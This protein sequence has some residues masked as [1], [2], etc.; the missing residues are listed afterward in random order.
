VVTV[1][2]SAS[3]AALNLD[4]SFYEFHSGAGSNW[5]FDKKSVTGSNSGGT[6]S[7]S[8]GVTPVTSQ[9][10][11]VVIGACAASGTTTSAG[12]TGWTGS[13]SG[14]NGWSEYELVSSQTA[15]AASFTVA[16]TGH[17]W[18]AGVG[19]WYAFSAPFRPMPVIRSGSSS[20][21][22]VTKMTPSPDAFVQQAQNI[23][24]NSGAISCP[25]SINA[26]HA[27]NLIVVYIGT[28]STGAIIT[29]VT[30]NKNNVYTLAFKDTAFNA[31]LFCYHCLGCIAG[32]TTV[33]V[34]SSAS[35]NSNQL[36][37]SVYEMSGIGSWAFDK[38][39][40]SGSNSGTTA[41]TSGTT[42]AT[43][44]ANEVVIAACFANGTSVTA[45]T[46]GFTGEST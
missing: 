42:V 43:T 31:S 9:L 19:T 30:D 6:T 27:A 46:V 12:T 14:L 13:V 2:S 34:L 18:T 1:L 7:V 37:V 33:T 32:A 24:T 5:F 41:A 36:D 38:F 20:G 21:A 26:T 17:S 22:I 44:V 4:V 25:V 23:V 3:V 35:V 15:Y 28:L 11:E 40:V 29:S 16:A 10:N 39:S 45:G 8:S